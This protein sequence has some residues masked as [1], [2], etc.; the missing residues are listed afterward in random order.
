MFGDVFKHPQQLGVRLLVLGPQDEGLP[1]TLLLPLHELFE[2]IGRHRHFSLF[3]TLDRELPLWL[4]PD[5]QRLR[6]PA[7]V[8]ELD[9][10]QLL[11]AEAA[12]QC[13]Q[14][15]HSHVR[16]GCGKQGARLRRRIHVRKLFFIAGS[17]RD[18]L[19]VDTAKSKPGSKAHVLVGNRAVS[20]LVL[21]QPLV[22]RKDVVLCHLVNLAYLHQ[23]KELLA[24]QSGLLGGLIGAALHS[25]V[26]VGRSRR[27]QGLA[28]R[29][30]NY[31]NPGLLR[32][33][34]NRTLD[35]KLLPSGVG[36]GGALPYRE[37]T[38]KYAVFRSTVYLRSYVQFLTETI[39][40]SISAWPGLTR[41]LAPLAAGLRIQVPAPFLKRIMS[42][43]ALPSMLGII[44]ICTTS[45]RQ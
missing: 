43:T 11:V 39:L 37:S 35:L 12:F 10:T 29:R 7:D 17:G 34:F 14:N 21:S 13:D 31:F 44:A 23:P 9:V 6:F 42:V 8:P 19:G 41:P 24:D 18:L 36:R 25:I 22:V 28:L 45:A 30:F 38:G 27:F 16:V 1:W 33:G 32:L 15:A 26:D 3:P 4:G 40:S 20:T 2:Q 5:S